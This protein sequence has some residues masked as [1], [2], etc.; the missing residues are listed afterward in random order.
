MARSAPAESNLFTTAMLVKASPAYGSKF[1]Q[2][3][4]M[5]SYLISCTDLLQSFPVPV[6]FPSMMCLMFGLAPQVEQSRIQG[7]FVGRYYHNSVTNTTQS[8]PEIGCGCGSRGNPPTCHPT[9]NA[10]QGGR[11]LSGTTAQMGR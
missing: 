6:L 4:L 5:I 9:C 7:C 11:N 2:I 1:R 3:G 8:A 10:P